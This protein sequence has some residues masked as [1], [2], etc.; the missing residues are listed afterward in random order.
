[1][2]GIALIVGTGADRSRFRSMIGALAPRGDR[3]EVLLEDG[4]LCGTQRLMIVDR[5]RAVQPWLS[6][7]GRWAL[8]YNGEVFNYR[9]L[10]DELKAA[11]HELRSEGD[12]EVVLEA[13]L[14][15]GESA[16]DHLR[17]EFAFAIIERP[18]G[19]VFLARDPVGVK[20][21]YWSRRDG[22]LHVASEVKA[23]VT[24]GAPITEVPPGYQGWAS[25]DEGPDLWP[26]VDLLALGEGEP[27]ID[28]VDE[29][30]ELIRTTL[31]DSIRVRVD[32]DLTVGVILS[33]GLDSSLTLLHVHDMHP[34]CV[35]FTVGTPD[36]E[37][38][39]YARRLT[40]ELGVPHEVIELR[41]GDIHLD[42]IKTAIRLSELT[43]YGDTIN[44]VVSTPLFRRV[45][46]T[47]VK[48]VL[49]GDGSDELFGGYDMYGQIGGDLRQR[50]FQ[51]KLRHLCRTELQ[52]VDRTSMGQGVECRVPFLDL[53]LVR[54]AMRMPIELKVRN[55]QE[56][57]IVRH[58]FADVLPDY[59]RQR[60]KN[61]M[62][63]SSGLHERARLYKP[64]FARLHRS[65]G[66]DMLDPVRRDFSIVLEQNG[67]D[68]D[69]ALASAEERPDYTALEHARDLLGAVRWNATTAARTLASRRSTTL[70][71]VGSP[72]G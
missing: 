29:A 53:A 68:L 62:S 5:D 47:G 22:C 15:W 27:P 23:M 56:K 21:L 7:D 57:W 30:A 42:D 24:V 9:A 8:C 6:T 14:E 59:I 60:P 50:L 52:R 39:E 67:L 3:E 64:L 45:H 26:F 10:R 4:V 32:T 49:A 69:R 34:D 20:P 19:R 31:A 61:P 41:P 65:F 63:H 66:Y 37:D 33:G 35:A 71:A 16:V 46:E 2:C 55:G 12:T 36:S 25:A 1:M 48:V 11:G 70:A 44:A 40:A 28:D 54:L 72:S 13:F 43:E 17:G 18:T 58:A 38:L 51:Y